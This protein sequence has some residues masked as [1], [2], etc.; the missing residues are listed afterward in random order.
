MNKKET[1]PKYT[2]ELTSCINGYQLTYYYNDG[3]VSDVAET[4][5]K[6]VKIIK[7]L[8]ESNQ[9]EDKNVD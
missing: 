8:L 4:A 1:Y 6:A 7:T 2:I 9:G 3:S 5:A